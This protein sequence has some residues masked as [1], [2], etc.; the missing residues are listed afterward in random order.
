MRVLASAGASQDI[1]VRDKYIVHADRTHC[2]IGEKPASELDE[3][4]GVRIWRAK[5]S[6]DILSSEMATAWEQKEM[7]SG[8]RR[9]LAGQNLA[10][11]RPLRSLKCT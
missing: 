7:H 11:A 9:Q 3:L 5:L 1:A 8:L 4:K 6:S 10:S 2:P